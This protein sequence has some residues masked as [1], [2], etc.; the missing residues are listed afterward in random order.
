MPLVI[1]SES[2]LA[3]LACVPAFAATH[4]EGAAIK[5]RKALLGDGRHSD[6]PT[7]AEQGFPGF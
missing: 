6:V 1:S 7:I 2:F 3:S 4:H 5:T